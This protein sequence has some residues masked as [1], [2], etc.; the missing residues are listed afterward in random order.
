[1]HRSRQ[2]R[3]FYG[4]MLLAILL[5]LLM[6]RLAWIQLVMKHQ[7]MPGTKR[8]LLESS[9]L[10]RERAVVLDTGRGHFLDRN[11]S[12]LTGKLIWT[13][14]LF[15]VPER[16]MLSEDS[17]E[18][19]AEILQSDPNDLT[20]I[21]TG[22]KEPRLW[23]GKDGRLPVPL[24]EQQQQAL[25]A[26]QLPYVKILP[27]EQRYGDME[28]GMQWLGFISGQR[29]ENQF[30]EHYQ[31]VMGTSGLEKTLDPLL[32]GISPT[33]IS[34]TVDSKNRLIQ[35]FDPMVKAD[36][37]P[38]YPLRFTTTVD[39]TIQKGI[40][41]LMSEA[42][43]KEG[44]VVVQDVSN[45]DIIAMVSLPFYNPERVNPEEG[46]WENRALQSTSPGSVFKIITAAAALETGAVSAKDTFHCSGQFGHYGLSCWKEHGHGTLDLREGFAQSCNVVF[47]ELGTRLS[48]AQIQDTANKLGLGYEAGWQAAHVLGLKLFKP[49]DHEERGM[50]FAQGTDSRDEGVRVQTAIGQRD[51]S[52]TPLQAS[53]LIV[54]L[55]NEGRGFRPRMI[56]RISYANGQ[57]LHSFPVLQNRLFD[58]I[59]KKT[60]RTLLEWMQDVVNEGTG[61]TLKKTAAW[62]LAGKSGTA[63]V[64]S[65]GSPRNNQ[66]FVGYGPVK[67][68][69]Y[70]VSVLVKNMK[71]G[72]RHQ[73]TD[74]FGDIMNLLAGT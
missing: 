18:R 20:K 19:T 68:P 44:A 22:L 36:S 6:G 24:S 48:G 55:L 27:Y 11:G 30:F 40:E 58:T 31:N 50:V 57:E 63:E 41:K 7:H 25:T 38:Y 72:S 52:M 17:I 1:M 64:L 53:N 46:Q 28:S 71:P 39:R 23:H 3:I 15:P 62:Q 47:A 12:A 35:E 4:W 26:L 70:A 51:V 59:S 67:Q 66:W 61:K 29:K 32:Q 14:V 37:N 42:G 54:T 16:S 8:T 56:S 2:H 43:V 69:R 10:Q 34:F 65:K 60:A 9:K 5:F 13:A 45:G 73:A 21:W 49:L 74:L 33:I